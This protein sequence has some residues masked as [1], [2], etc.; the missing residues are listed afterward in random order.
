[1]KK[2]ETELKSETPFALLHPKVRKEDA[3]ARIVELRLRR[4]MTQPELAESIGMKLP[5]IKDYEAGKSF[6]GYQAIRGFALAGFDLKSLL[7]LEKDGTS[8]VREEPAT[9]GQLPP[10]PVDIDILA[11]VINAIGDRLRGESLPAKKYA[12]LIALT[13]KYTIASGSIDAGY[14]DQLLRITK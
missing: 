11:R 10:Q 4:Q 12:E 7:F 3:A 2:S 6:P 5:T 1:M 8:E 14:I 13:Y 9:Y